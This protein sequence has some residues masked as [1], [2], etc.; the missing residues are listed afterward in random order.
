MTLAVVKSPQSHLAFG[1]AAWR[2][3]VTDV[4]RDK[5]SPLS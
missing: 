1:P 4:K 3:F 2:A 5:Y